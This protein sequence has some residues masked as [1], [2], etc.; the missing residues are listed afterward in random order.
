MVQARV[1]AEQADNSTD[2]EKSAAADSLNKAVNSLSLRGGDKILSQND[3]WEA[4][5]QHFKNYDG[6]VREYLPNAS[7]EFLDGTDSNIAS[8]GEGTS[9]TAINYLFD[10][11]STGSDGN[12]G[13]GA[14]GVRRSPQSFCMIW[15]RRVTSMALML[16]HISI[17]AEKSSVTMM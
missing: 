8:R 17:T 5:W 1:A 14:A 7:A 4:D 6:I 10:G 12:S 15:E 9:K 13:C 11:Y 2:A 16:R 3:M